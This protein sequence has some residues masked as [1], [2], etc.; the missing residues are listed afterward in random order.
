MRGNIFL[1]KLYSSCRLGEGVEENAGSQT[2]KLDHL[3]R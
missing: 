2:H 1:T 3:E